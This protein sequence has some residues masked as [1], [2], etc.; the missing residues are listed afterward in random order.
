MNKLKEKINKKGAG[1]VES[2]IDYMLIFVIGLF[3]FI[4]LFTLLSLSLLFRAEA[5]V[6]AVE[7]SQTAENLIFQQRAAYVEGLVV[8]IDT[9]KAN[10]NYVNKYKLPPPKPVEPRSGRFT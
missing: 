9:L 6:L 1:P 2:W 8:N 10:V 4:F 5:T 7:S 3:G